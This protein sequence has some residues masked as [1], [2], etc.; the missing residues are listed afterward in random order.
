[1]VRA[2]HRTFDQKHSRQVYRCDM[3]L[4]TWICDWCGD[5]I[6][7]PMKALLLWS[8]SEIGGLKS[9][10][11]IVHKGNRCDVDQNDHST[12]LS[13]VLGLDGQ[14]YLFSLITDGPLRGGT[15]RGVESLDEWSDVF[16]RLQTPWYE[17]ARPHFRDEEIQLRFSDANEMAPYSQGSLRDIAAGED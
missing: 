5:D 11:R 6:T 12:E 1:M 15:V 2:T 3:P 10:F 17:E 14:A 9:N 7:N 16:R 8:A 13:Y 4:N